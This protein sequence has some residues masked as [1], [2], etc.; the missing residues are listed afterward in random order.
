[1]PGARQFHAFADHR[2]E[3]HRDALAGGLLL[4]DGARLQHLLHRTH[5]ALGID[6]HQFVELAAAGLIHL[7]AL[8]GFEVEANRSDRRLELVGYRVDEAVVLLIAANLADQKNCIEDEPGD[9]GAEK[10]N[11]E[12]DLDAFTPVE[13][14]PSA[15]NGEGKRRQAHAERQEERNRF[16]PAGDPHREIVARKNLQRRGHRGNAQSSQESIRKEKAG[17]FPG[18]LFLCALCVLFPAL[19]ALSSNHAPRP[20]LAP[21]LPSHPEP[22]PAWAAGYQVGFYTRAA[23]AQVSSMPKCRTS[24]YRLRTTADRGAP[25]LDAHDD[26]CASLRQT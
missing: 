24:S 3:V 25:K 1:M 5:E 17:A 4:G 11:A 15:A 13:D 21:R 2:I 10:D 7:A 18:G 8:Q 12:K 19:S 22:A 20:P 16:A 6:Q 14:D 26:C 9:D 23:P